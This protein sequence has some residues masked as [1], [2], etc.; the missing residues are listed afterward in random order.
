MM[1]DK[2]NSQPDT[3][4]KVFHFFIRESS[5]RSRV[6]YCNNRKQRLY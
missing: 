4:Y 5:K 6:P 1:I 3:V 2:V